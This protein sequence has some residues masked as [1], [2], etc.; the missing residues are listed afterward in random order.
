M[1]GD[2]SSTKISRKIALARWLMVTLAKP[3][4]APWN[5]I[6]REAAKGVLIAVEK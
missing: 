6:M 4:Q 1:L 2:K 3:R 5:S